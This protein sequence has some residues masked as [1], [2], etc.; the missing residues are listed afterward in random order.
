[1][2]R[3]GSDE[4][5]ETRPL[6]SL[7]SL[8]SL[9]V[10]RR[11]YSRACPHASH[12]QQVRTR[13]TPDR[14]FERHSATGAAGRLRS[15]TRLP[16]CGTGASARLSGVGAPDGRVPPPGRS[17]PGSAS[18]PAALTQCSCPPQEEPRPR[19]VPTARLVSAPRHE[20]GPGRASGSPISDT[21]ARNSITGGEHQLGNRGEVE[22]RV[23]RQCRS[24]F[25]SRRSIP[26]VRAAPLEPGERAIR[27]GSRFPG[28]VACEGLA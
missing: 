11:R 23:P 17:L 14:R 25:A 10:S 16:E 2:S 13:R 28:P 15:P 18:A 26:A 22:T 20:T 27:A 19:P 8:D 1:M 9:D 5:L 21:P 3:R 12:R 6:V 7:V 4:R 24:S